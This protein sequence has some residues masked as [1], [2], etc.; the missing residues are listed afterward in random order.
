[1]VS[2]F[3]PS[4]VDQT[5]TSEASDIFELGVEFSAYATILLA[6]VVITIALTNILIGLSVNI[7]TE[8]LKEAEYQRL[9]A[10]AHKL[11][12]IAP[13]WQGDLG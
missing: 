10:M 4:I 2:S 12:G 3:N 9:S 5:I 11:C 8:G 7:A 6:F 13:L 1:M